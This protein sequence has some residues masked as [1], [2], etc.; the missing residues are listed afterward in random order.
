MT[1]KL[2]NIPEDLDRALRE[3]AAAEN[4]SPES[5]IVD[6][7]ASGLNATLQPARTKETCSDY[8]THWREDHEFEAALRDQ[9]LID[10][11]VWNDGI[12]RRDLTGIAGQHLITPE[13]KEVFAE[14]R[15]IDP[16]LWK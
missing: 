14:Q 10:W 13:M 11:E 2:E 16:E 1:Y 5:I 15:R 4:K 6:L 9:N 8:V 12:Q 7:L 3:R